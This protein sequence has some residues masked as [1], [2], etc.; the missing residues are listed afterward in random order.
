MRLSCE[1]ASGSTTLAA[2][3]TK[4]AKTVFGIWGATCFTWDP[5]EHYA[6]D[7]GERPLRFDCARFLGLLNGGAEDATVDCSDVA[8]IASTFASILGCPLSQLAI[9][10]RVPTNFVRLVGHGTWRSKRFALHEFA[11]SGA[12]R[13]AL[14]S[15]PRI[16]DACVEVSGDRTIVPKKKPHRPLLPV[17]L[18][19]GNYLFRLLGLRRGR[20]KDVINER[21]FG[22]ADRSAADERPPCR[23]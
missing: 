15:R 2:A 14:G 7:V 17:S 21:P 1:A 23:V 22:A 8:A 11:V 6:T 4:V 13:R 12:V 10:T 20:L 18:T 16:W 19:P 5:G 9:T 3:A